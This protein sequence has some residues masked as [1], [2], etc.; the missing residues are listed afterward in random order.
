MT[1]KIIID[2]DRCKGC[3]LCI[4]VC[5]AKT[6]VMSDKPNSAGHFPAE[7]AGGGCTACAMCAVICPDCAI[8]VLGFEETPKKPREAGRRQPAAGRKSK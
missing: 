8:E 1:G 2:R 3:G 4:W 6:I 7:T 5:P